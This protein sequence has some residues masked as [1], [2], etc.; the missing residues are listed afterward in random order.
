MFTTVLVRSCSRIVN[1]SNKAQ[2]IQQVQTGEE[3]LVSPSMDA[4]NSAFNLTS[5]GPATIHLL[6][7]CLRALSE[8]LQLHHHSSQ[9][10]C[11]A[12]VPDQLPWMP[13]FF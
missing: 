13:F 7:E 1:H 12:H 9:Q 3:K 2:T 5:P 8:T 11:S 4:S 6:S 10:H